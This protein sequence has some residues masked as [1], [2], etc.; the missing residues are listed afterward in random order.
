MFDT[1]PETE[2]TFFGGEGEGGAEHSS[3]LHCFVQC[4]NMFKIHLWVFC[5]R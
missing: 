2:S 5:G 1:K 3:V 4:I